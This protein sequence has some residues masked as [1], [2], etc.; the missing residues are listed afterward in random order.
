MEIVNPDPAVLA[1]RTEEW[2]AEMRDNQLDRALAP[3]QMTMITLG[4][5]I[6]TGLVLGSGAALERGGPWGL[7]VGFGF[8]GSICYANLQSITEMATYLP[9][10]RGFAGY[11]SRFWHPAVGFAVGWTFLFKLL[12]VMAGHVN[13][14]VL[15]FNY[16][17]WTW[18]HH[19]ALKAVWILIHLSI[20]VGINLLRVSRYAR[21]EFHLVSLK[22]SVLIILI[23]TGIVLNTGGNPL[24]AR[25][26]FQFWTEPHGPFRVYFHT[27]N[28]D[29]SR[30]V[31]F[32]VVMTKAFYAYLGTEVFAVCIG[33]AREPRVA[34][35]RAARQ[36]F[37]TV[38]GLYMLGVLVIGLIVPRYSDVNGF[39][40]NDF[41]TNTTNIPVEGHC[42][43]KDPKFDS[44]SQL[45]ISPF[46]VA[47][48]LFCVRALPSIINASLVIFVI[49]APASDL[50]IAS[51]ILRGLA[52]E[53]KAP[54]FFTRLRRGVPLR[55]VAAC[56]CCGLFA[57]ASFASAP[58]KFF[59][60]VTDMAT[61]F[62]LITWMAIFYAHIRFMDAYWLKNGHHP[63]VR[64]R[65]QPY[66]SWYGLFG[67]GIITLFKGMEMFFSKDSDRWGQLVIAY[68]GLPIFV[69]LLFFW[70]WKKGLRTIP[71][72]EVNLNVRDLYSD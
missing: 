72:D 67:T 32:W 59:D 18:A 10:S 54:S 37:W 58:Q 6:G 62:G 35:P 56:A 71:I 15:I 2:Q 46:V 30:F 60:Y 63:E 61:I 14:F 12:V 47:A 51:R 31:G 27:K 5:T 70:R 28:D 45:P 68:I 17:R 13:S 65:F 24:K 69:V 29:L 41:L 44:Q 36:I 9:H 21:I 34:I 4:G 48:E 42:L 8:M 53:G 64:S 22:I 23:F 50:Y 38:F 16:T 25:L 20:I 57:F 1:Q 49:S 55:A 3:K 52:V 40:E 33:E 11:I 66:L 43:R 7:I 19:P 39:F 26:N